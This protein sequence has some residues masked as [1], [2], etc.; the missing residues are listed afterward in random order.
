DDLRIEQVLS[1]RFELPVSCPQQWNAENPYLYQLLLSLYDGAGNLLGVVPQ[2]VGFREI[3]VRDGLMYVNG[4]YLKLHGVNRH[5]HDHRKGRAVDMA[6]VERDIVLMK[7]H[8]INSVRTAHYPND[9]RFYELC[10]LYGLFVMAETDLE[11]HGFA[12]V[13]D[14]SRITDD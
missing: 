9:P 13:G 2:R 7:Q 14:L 8:N 12:N 3:A 6:R 4:R 11:S 10:D 5:D 1:C